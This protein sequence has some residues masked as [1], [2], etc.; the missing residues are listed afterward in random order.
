MVREMLYPPSHADLVA[1]ALDYVRQNHPNY[2]RSISD[3]ER[4]A[5]AEADAARAE[6]YARILI[7]QGVFESDAWSR[8]IREM[9]FCGTGD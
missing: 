5:E 8:S 4:Q 9:I 3:A 2:W 1:K 6:R 7:S